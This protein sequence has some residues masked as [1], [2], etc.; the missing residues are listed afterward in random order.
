M[1]RYITPAE[2]ADVVAR[3]RPADEKEL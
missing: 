3:H 1:Y 2:T